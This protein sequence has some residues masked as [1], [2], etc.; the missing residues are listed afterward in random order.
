M[1][2]LALKQAMGTRSSLILSMEFIQMMWLLHTGIS[3]MPG[4]FSKMRKIRSSCKYLE[5]NGFAF[6]IAEKDTRHSDGI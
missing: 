2:S 3:A 1:W 4:N 6:I 5:S